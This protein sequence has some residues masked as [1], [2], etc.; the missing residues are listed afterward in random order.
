MPHDFG[1]SSFQPPGCT[2]EA[3]L[4]ATEPDMLELTDPL[5]EESPVPQRS[6]FSRSSSLVGY[7]SSSQDPCLGPR[8]LMARF[9]SNGSFVDSD[10]DL[11]SSQES[12]ISL[13]DLEA[14]V[15]KHDLESQDSDILMAPPEDIS[16]PRKRILDE[17]ME[18]PRNSTPPP[19]GELPDIVDDLSSKLNPVTPTKAEDC[20]GVV[21]I[22]PLTPMANLKMLISAASPEIRNREK[23]R[24]LLGNGASQ[25]PLHFRSS[26]HSGE[27]QAPQV[28]TL[29]PP[30]K[31]GR[32]GKKAKAKCK[33]P[34]DIKTETDE[35]SPAV[36]SMF[37]GS[38]TDEPLEDQPQVTGRKERSLGLL[39]KRW[40]KT[41]VCSFFE[42]L[43]N[44]FYNNKVIYRNTW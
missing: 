41:A 3:L 33:F 25:D 43:D 38:L 20:Q 31:P 24:E 34:L 32:K 11:N 1:S 39:C 12:K 36:M 2:M 42:R 4:E 19:H 15:A 6:F 17:G 28:A 23:L 30:S 37:E 35:E 9:N 26:S 21:E 7:V 10:A 8:H 27:V 5:K 14:L 22:D 29:N 40:V 13:S 44:F 16:V 18:I